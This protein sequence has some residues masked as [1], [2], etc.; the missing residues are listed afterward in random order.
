MIDPVARPD[1]QNGLHE[2]AF[3]AFGARAAVSVDRQDHVDRITDLLPPGWHPCDPSLVSRKYELVSDTGGSYE[4]RRDGLAL[5]TGLSPDLALAVLDSQL[6][7]F[8]AF[9][10]PD[11]IFVHAGV[12]AFNGKALVVPGKS[13]A[14]K[15]TLVAALVRAGATYYSDEFAVLDERGAIHPYPKPLSIRPPENRWVQVN[16]PVDTLEGEVGNG[17]VP[18]ELVAKSPHIDPERLGN[19][20]DFCWGR[21]PS[22]SWNTQWWPRSGR[23]R[24]FGP[25]HWRCAARLCSRASAVKL[26]R[27]PRFCLPSWELEFVGERPWVSRVHNVRGQDIWAHRSVLLALV[28]I[29]MA[30]STST[31]IAAPPGFVGMTPTTCTSTPVTTATPTCWLSAPPALTSCG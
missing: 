6:R 15:T 26:R 25:S 11:T 22:L 9:F 31:A 14:G 16:H 7:G 3:E 29:V 30:V 4:L 12:V 13:F 19:P 8:V 18:L 5:T 24:R 10:A 1:S 28:A 21:R 2:I 20:G 23:R 27:S 17:P